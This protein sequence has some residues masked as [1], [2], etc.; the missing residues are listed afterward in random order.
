MKKL[1]RV[2]VPLGMALTV[3]SSRAG[4]AE[5][6]APDAG[7]GGVGV[8][9]KVGTLGIGGELTIGINDHVGLRLGGNAFS[10]EP[11]WRADEGTIYADLDWL[12][13]TGLLDLHP[14]GGGFRITGGVVYNRNKFKLRA[15]LDEPV[16]LAGADYWLSDLHGEV[17][18]PDFA[19]YIG[20][21]YGNAAGR[22]GRWHFSCDF[23]VMFQGEPRVQA[24]ATASNPLLQPIVDRALEEELDDIRDDASNFQ[25]YPVIS[26]GLSFRF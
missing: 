2:I 25:Y 3:W 16:E 1:W 12:S 18:F 24:E 10:W 7:T 17:T 21:G 8:S 19:P 23:G 5:T 15:D 11:D 13:W 22:D 26:C 20:I 9:A 14:F 6:A 4:G